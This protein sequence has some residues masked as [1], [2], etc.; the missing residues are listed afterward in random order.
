MYTYSFFDDAMNIRDI[1]DEFFTRR[2]YNEPYKDFP[3]V[4][5]VEGDDKLTITS[6]MPGLKPE[7][8]D[9]QLVNENL[10]I[11]GDKKTDYEEK[12]YLRKERFF[13]EFKK[14]IKLPY[15]VDHNKIKADLK[16]GI[17]TV[18]LEK[19]DDAKPKKI[20]IL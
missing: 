15:S 11:T 1:F 14:S 7:D 6:L 3:F 10:T 2:T 20:E 19:S 8:I 13:G 12:P 5:I 4:R 16:D 18:T 17:L 9:I